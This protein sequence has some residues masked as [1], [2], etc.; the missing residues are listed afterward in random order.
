MTPNAQSPA[1]GNKT[2]NYV[3]GVTG[4]SGAAYAVRLLDVLVAAGHDI[5]LSISPAGQ[6]VLRQELGLEVDLTNFRVETLLPDR[7]RLVAD[8][9]FARLRAIVGRQRLATGDAACPGRVRLLPPSGP[10]CPDGQRIGPDR[11]HGRVPLLRRNAR[12]RSRRAQSA[13]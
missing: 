10:V 12:A 3:L 13:T 11:R 4:A 1:T 7:E 6:S 2:A 8:K 5:Q 9:T